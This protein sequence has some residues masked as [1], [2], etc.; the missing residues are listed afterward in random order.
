MDSASDNLEIV[1]TQA[2]KAISNAEVAVTRSE[3]S[4][5]AAE[6]TLADLKTDPDPLEIES[7]EKD[8]ALGL[9]NLD[10]AEE[11]LRDLSSGPDPV[12]VEAKR[13]QVA[14]AQA[15]LVAALDELSELTDEPDPLDVDAA[16]NQVAVARANLEAAGDDLSE[17]T[18]EPDPVELD[19]KANQVAV[20]LASLDEAEDKLAE[21]LGAVDPLEVALRQADMASARLPLDSSL[22]LLNGATLVA[23][24]SGI[25]SLVNVEAGQSINANI[26]AVEIVDPTVIEVDGIVDEI[27]VMFVQVGASAEVTMDALPGQVLQGTVS[28]VALAAE[29]QQGVVSY[30]IRIQVQLPQGIQPVE[31]L[32]ATASI[33]IREDSDVLL[34]PLQ[35]LYGTFERPLVRVSNGGAVEERPVSVGNSDD[36]W[37]VILALQRRLV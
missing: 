29:T 22:D 28:S 2:A 1:E 23:P 31:G 16:R 21:L 6:E 4:L 10:E 35:A 12:E 30:P 20:A 27:D 24:M 18:S 36:F 34:V 9:A 7:R 3:E 17:L 5:A 25:V 15:N 19:A 13:K 8:L 33:V 37:A 32:S 14:L 11:N 26:R